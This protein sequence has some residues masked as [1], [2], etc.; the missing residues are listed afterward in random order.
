M[1]LICVGREQRE[2]GVSYLI[3]RERVANSAG[4]NP[5]LEA[6]LVG[7]PVSHARHDPV[8]WHQR[9]SS[10]TRKVSVAPGHRERSGTRRELRYQLDR[11]RIPGQPLPVTQGFDGFGITWARSSALIGAVTLKSASAKAPEDSG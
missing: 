6:H 8:L 3:R 11:H 4:V 1:F 2:R 7:D 5:R 10:A 9:D